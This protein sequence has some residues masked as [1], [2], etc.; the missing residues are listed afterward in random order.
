[1]EVKLLKY[2]QLFHDT[3]SCIFIQSYSAQDQEETVELMCLLAFDTSLFPVSAESPLLITFLQSLA[4]R[5]LYYQ[6]CHFLCPGPAASEA[7]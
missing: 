1:M 5:K 7:A 3:F 4:V 2:T 6:C